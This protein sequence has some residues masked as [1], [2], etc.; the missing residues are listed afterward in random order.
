M[1][2]S[3]T[4]PGDRESS[5]VDMAAQ[6]AGDDPTATVLARRRELIG[7]L[8]VTLAGMKPQ[9]RR[10]IEMFHLEGRS[11]EDVAAELGMTTG[12][13]RGLLHRARSSLRTAISRLSN[14]V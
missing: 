9:H 7:V 6:V 14:F 4:P 5:Y 12:Q 8:H 11:L 3:K 1:A 13:V 10:V 2:A